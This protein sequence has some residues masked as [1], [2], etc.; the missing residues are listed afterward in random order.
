M[1]SHK[2]QVIC[3]LSWHQG[4]LYT[5]FIKPFLALAT[6][7]LNV[8]SIT[9]LAVLFPDCQKNTYVK[10]HNVALPFVNS[11]SQCITCATM[12]TIFRNCCPNTKRVTARFTCL[13]VSGAIIITLNGYR[14]KNTRVF[15]C[16][17]QYLCETIAKILNS[18]KLVQ[19]NKICKD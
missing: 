9:A 15:V 13:I 14:L 12:Q 17:C 16:K 5:F 10:E 19:K 7:P 8:L 2:W 18:I 11:Q 3:C 4:L 6:R 1:I